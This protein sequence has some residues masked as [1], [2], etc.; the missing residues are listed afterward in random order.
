MGSLTPGCSDLPLPRHDRFRSTAEEV[1]AL[2]AEEQLSAMV[3]EHL[4]R[5]R[6]Q[7]RTAEQRSW[8]VSLP[9]LATD[10]SEIGLGKVQM[11]IEYRL[12]ESSR[13][14]D[15][16]LAGV[17]PETGEDNYVVIE[18]K[19]WSRAELTWNSDRIVRASGVRDEQL[20]PIDQVRGY[21][22]YLTQFVEALHTRPESVHGVAYLHNATETS[23]STLRARQPDAMGRLFTGEQH[24]ELR[25]YLKA[26]F[27]PQTGVEAA[28]RLLTSAIRPK[29]NLFAFTGAELRA[30]TEYTL[31]DHQKLAYEAV[32]TQV[33]LARQSDRKSVVIVTG[34]PGSG[35][36]LIAVSL[37]AELHRDGYRVR[38]ATGSSAFTESL[39]K[40]P[41]KGSTELQG[42]FKYFRNFAD[43][44]ANELDVLICD[45]AHRIREVS[46]N[47]FTPRAAR[48]NRPQLD[49]L[50]AVAR[51]PVFL[52]DEHQVVR[53]DEV[54]TVKEIKSHAARS[55]YLV[56]EIELDGQFRCGGSAAYEEWVRRL[57]GLR[58]GGPTPWSGDPAFDVRTADSPEEM[59][60]FLR[61]KNADGFTARMSAGYCWPWSSPTEDGALVADVSIGD[62]ERPW[63]LRG[64]R[65]VGDAPPSPL[66]ATDPRGFGQIGCIYT[67]QGFEYD[68][69]G[70]ILGP[71][72]VAR[73]GQLISV[74]EKTFDP[75]LKGT[76]KKPV[77]PDTFD[78]LVRNIYK[79]L[80]TRGMRG[81]V[82]YSVDPATRRFLSELVGQS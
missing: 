49:E 15:V 8:D 40:F 58:V 24:H 70:V 9:W 37:L 6:R 32:M 17:H 38:H 69:G 77:A 18:L 34:G 30:A 46:T 62:W 26:Q 65:A 31:L 74:P 53:P 73:D 42:L 41:A 76:K 63:N 54:G 71:D 52:L 55:G 2:S 27:A 11:L 43:L 56:H 51:V 50:M 21:C 4:G 19:Q 7:Q 67:A 72:L 60:E 14:A 39:R 75:A 16:I 25:A 82:I 57:L 23:V 48:T 35:K 64:D 45:E 81:V 78:V 47:R 36:S 3:T 66:W 1:L 10:L 68:W 44:P 20:H 29:P 80:L 22:R 33:R 5:K 61:Q 12:P 79:V 13:R 59:E 28:D